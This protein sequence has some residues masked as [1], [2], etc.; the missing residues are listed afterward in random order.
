MVIRNLGLFLIFSRNFPPIKAQEAINVVT[1]SQNGNKNVR[2]I[3]NFN[4]NFPPV[5]GS[6]ANQ[7]SE[8]ESKW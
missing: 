2:F 7:Y 5:K 8:L 1:C 3:V 6:R 4:S